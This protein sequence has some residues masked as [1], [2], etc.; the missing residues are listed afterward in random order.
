MST[1]PKGRGL[2]QT[3][4][5][6]ARRMG[7]ADHQRLT[8]VSYQVLTP[9]MSAARTTPTRAGSRCHKR[10]PAGTTGHRSTHRDHANRAYH[11]AD[12]HLSELRFAD[13]SRVPPL[14]AQ[15]A[16]ALVIRLYEAVRPPERS[17]SGAASSL[18][19]TAP[20]PT[21]S[22]DGRPAL[23]LVYHP[24]SLITIRPGGSS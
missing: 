7:P 12:Q 8:S 6:N 15:R 13:H 23:A 11:P 5:L 16:G 18:R 1:T 9:R 10:S 2:A 17:T 24:S 4:L 20:Q 19:T 3:P 21:R 22:A 14:A